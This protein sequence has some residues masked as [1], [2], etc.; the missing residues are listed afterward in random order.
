MRK[1]ANTDMYN[2][3]IQRIKN[4]NTDAKRELVDFTVFEFKEEFLNCL[5]NAK[6]KVEKQDL[7]GFMYPILW[8]YLNK[9][10]IY[11]NFS[12]YKACVLKAVDSR[13]TK[14]KKLRRNVKNDFAFDHTAED[15]DKN[16]LINEGFVDP[17]DYVL[18]KEMREIICG[19]IAEL[20]PHMQTII[21]QYYGFD[22]DGQ[23]LFRS[24]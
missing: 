7:E 22:G 18:K 11:E 2:E 12:Q 19:L 15:I 17:D 16:I 13:L 4:G 8:D 21:L 5:R 24:W 3:I 14:Y 9:A 6:I 1:L 10:I 23:K 20:K